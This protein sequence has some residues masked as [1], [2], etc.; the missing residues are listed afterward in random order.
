MLLSL[1]VAG[2]HYVGA[3]VGGFFNNPDTELLVRWYQAGL[4]TNLSVFSIV[5]CCLILRS[6]RCLPTILSGT[7]AH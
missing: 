7:R 3:D 4:I 2:I 1:A 5:Y 6:H